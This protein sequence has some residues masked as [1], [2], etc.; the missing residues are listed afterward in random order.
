MSAKQYYDAG[1]MLYEQQKFDL[2]IEQ[3]KKALEDSPDF[4]EA[5]SFLA[6]CM[7]EK[8]QWRSASQLAA[9]AI[10]NN[11]SIGFPHYVAARIL[12]LRNY[13]AQALEEVNKAIELETEVASY[14][15]LAAMIRIDM[16]EWDTALDLA[17]QGLAVDPQNQYC[18]NA[19]AMSLTRMGR[20]DEAMADL[21]EM[22]K[23][24]ERMRGRPGTEER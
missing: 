13:H 9:E 7:A 8:K 23:E 22:L 14:F 24:I 4:A 1:R 20:A 19:R 2:A 12:W 18:H 11:P 10:A 21:E 5:K 15:G 3:F 16:Q 17:G 6:L